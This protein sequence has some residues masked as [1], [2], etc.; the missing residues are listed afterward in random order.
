MGGLYRQLHDVQ[1]GAVR[2]RIQAA[3]QKQPAA[4]M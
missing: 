2:R 4:L 3:L 1:S